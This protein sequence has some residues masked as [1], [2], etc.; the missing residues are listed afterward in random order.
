MWHT[1]AFMRRG[2]DVVVA[3]VFNLEIYSGLLNQHIPS[4]VPFESEFIT[5]LD[6]EGLGDS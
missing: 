6:G 2:N 1:W 4:V 3:A 5:R